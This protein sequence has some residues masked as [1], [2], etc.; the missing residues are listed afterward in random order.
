M[1]TVLRH[2]YE[3][4][5]ERSHR[6]QPFVGRSAQLLLLARPYQA[7]DRN[8]LHPSP[9]VL[10]PGHPRDLRRLR[11]KPLRRTGS[12]L[13]DAQHLSDARFRERKSTMSMKD[14][15]ANR[16]L[17]IHWPEGFA[18][19]AADLFSHNERTINASCERIWRHIIEANKWPEWYPNAKDVRILGDGSSVLKPNSVFFWTTFGLQ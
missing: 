11:T 4:R 5:T 1:G 18:P 8:A 12:H 7:G 17:D 14:D 2:Q 15:L 16:C 10:R 6:G 13:T 19:A 3:S 9:A